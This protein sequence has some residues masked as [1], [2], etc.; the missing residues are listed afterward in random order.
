MDFYNRTTGKFVPRYDKWLDSGGGCEKVAE[1]QQN[2]INNLSI[3][4]HAVARLVA[5]L[6]YKPKV[7]GFD[8]RWGYSD[9]SLT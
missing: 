4:A 9:F 7:S 5:A 8:S 2:E 1:Y 6:G 3:Y